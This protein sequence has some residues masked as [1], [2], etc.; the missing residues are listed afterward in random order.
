[1]PLWTTRSL[2][3]NTRPPAFAGPFDTLSGENDWPRE[4]TMMCLTFLRFLWP[5]R[6]PV[7]QVGCE[8]LEWWKLARDRLHFLEKKDPFNRSIFFLILSQNQPIEQAVCFPSFAYFDTFHPPIPIFHQNKK[9]GSSHE[10]L[11]FN[12]IVF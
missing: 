7:L 12:K 9:K 11:Q 5:S 1:M 10:H 3:P 6:F 2:S 8:R 4:K